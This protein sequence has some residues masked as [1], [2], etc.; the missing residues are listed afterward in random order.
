MTD[1]VLARQSSILAMM[2]LLAVPLN[3]AAR[4]DRQMATD[5]GQPACATVPIRRR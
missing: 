4:Q 2:I 3:L 5:P 1:A